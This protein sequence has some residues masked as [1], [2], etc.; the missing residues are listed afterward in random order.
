MICSIWD[1][2]SQLTF[3]EAAE[4]DPILYMKALD[5]RS[6]WKVLHVQ[7]RISPEGLIPC[8]DLHG[9]CL[10][11]RGAL[12]FLIFCGVLCSKLGCQVLCAALL[13]L[14]KYHHWVLS[15]IKKETHSLEPLRRTHCAMVNSIS[16]LLCTKRRGE[17]K[18]S[19]NL[20]L[21]FERAL[22]HWKKKSF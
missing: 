17:S 18:A 19:C 8:W 21:Q 7:L 22:P 14:C 9:R 15:I 4:V 6:R 11:L 10:R 20:S 16:E 13:K 5:S 1:T 3:H 12:P 2:A